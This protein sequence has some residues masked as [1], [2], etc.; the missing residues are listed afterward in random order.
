MPAAYQILLAV[1]QLQRECLGEGTSHGGGADMDDGY[2]RRPDLVPSA[3]QERARRAEDISPGSRLCWVGYEPYDRYLT[4]RRT[5]QHLN[6]SLVCD[7]S[8]SSPDPKFIAYSAGRLSLEW[9]TPDACPQSDYGLGGGGEAG[10]GLWSLIKFIF[11]FIVIG[12][13]IYFA[14]GTLILIPSMRELI[15][16]GIFYNHQQY[17]AKGWDLIPHRDFWRSTPDILR[18][19][20]S[21]VFANVRGGGGG[22]R[23]GY[24]SLG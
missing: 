12:L 10:V 17:S 7:R 9:A 3:R 2:T 15:L 22:S 13:I 14:I 19:L 20:F 18:D 23:G 24:S 16:P 6:L 1:T 4:R 21:H 11:W 5:S 8:A